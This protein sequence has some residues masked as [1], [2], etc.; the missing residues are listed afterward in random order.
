M[1]SEMKRINALNLEPTLP[2]LDDGTRN[3]RI[4]F[5]ETTR[6]ASR[7]AQGSG[8][9]KMEFQQSLEVIQKQEASKQRKQQT[10]GQSP[11]DMGNR[12]GPSPGGQQGPGG[13]DNS[14]WGQQQGQNYM[15]YPRKPDGSGTP[16]GP[17]GGYPAQGG[18]SGRAG[19]QFSFNAGAK[20]FSLNPQAGEFTPQG[21]AAAAGPAGNTAP[22]P[23]AAAP[24]TVQKPSAPQPVFAI[25]KKNQDLLRKNLAELLEPFF[26]KASKSAPDSLGP[27]WPDAKGSS[28]HEV[29]GQPNPS[30]RHQLMGNPMP[31]G[32]GPGPGPGWQQPQAPDQQGQ[33]TSGPGPQ[34]MQQ[35]FV[36]ANAPS[37]GPPNAMYQQVYAAAPGGGGPGGPQGPQGGGNMPPQ[38]VVFGQQTMMAQGPA[39]SMAAVPVGM[40]PSQSGMGPMPKF[41]GQQQQQQQ[42]VVMPVMLAPGQQNFVPQGFMPQQGQP[43]PPGPPGPQGPP[44]QQADGQ[45]GQMMQQPMFHRQGGAG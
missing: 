4:N 38:P 8:D 15:I 20:P 10:S 40:V 34:M 19:K 30:S 7:I 35:G 33:P 25:F 11:T 44:G 9:L 31:S 42:M 14:Q 41:G 3:A 26:Q 32:G 18:E 1:I 16:G 5:K 45:Q 29:L 17:Q 24:S 27:E 28:Y 13:P 37:G 22:T 23:Q 36:M 43:G 2:K 12:G 21:S 39:Q 6:N